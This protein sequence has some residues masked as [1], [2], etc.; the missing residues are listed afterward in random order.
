MGNGGGSAPSNRWRPGNHVLFLIVRLRAPIH[1]LVPS[2]MASPLRPSLA[3]VQRGV[4]PILSLITQINLGP[5]PRI[6]ASS[7]FPS[8]PLRPFHIWHRLHTGAH[9][10][11]ASSWCITRT[12]ASAGDSSA[13]PGNQ[14][15]LAAGGGDE[16]G[17]GRRH[18]RQD[19]FQNRGGST[20]PLRK[21]A[22]QVG[23]KSTLWP[24]RSCNF[25]V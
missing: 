15:Q 22:A 20:H 23:K 1:H 21:K 13:T 17:P 7:F 10:T 14:T 4:C 24:S 8:A 18:D 25:A 6:T 19:R 9:T 16:S 11:A 12:A 3:P 2:P 5:R